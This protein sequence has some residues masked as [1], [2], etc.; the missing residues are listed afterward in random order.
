MPD[1]SAWGIGAL[2]HNG[3]SHE[4]VSSVYV[5]EQALLGHYVNG[6][7]GI[8]K[9]EDNMY[10]ESVDWGRCFPDEG[11]GER[12]MVFS[13]VM[14][15]G[16]KQVWELE[17]DER[18]IARTEEMLPSI[19]RIM[20]ERLLGPA[21]KEKGI[22]RESIS[23]N[24]VPVILHPYT[25]GALTAEAE[26]IKVLIEGD[27][28]LRGYAEAI[29]KL[30]SF[31]YHERSE[32]ILSL[33]GINAEILKQDRGMRELPNKDG[34]V[35]WARSMGFGYTYDGY[36]INLDL[37]KQSPWSISAVQFFLV[38]QD[39]DSEHCVLETDDGLFIS[40]AINVSPGPQEGVK[41]SQIVRAYAQDGFKGAEMELDG[42]N[43]MTVSVCDVAGNEFVVKAASFGVA[44]A[45]EKEVCWQVDGASRF[46]FRSLERHLVLQAREQSTPQGHLAALYSML[47]GIPGGMLSIPLPELGT[48]TRVL[49]EQILSGALVRHPFADLGNI[50]EAR[51]GVAKK[52]DPGVGPKGGGGPE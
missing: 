43:C 14:P 41:L 11:E 24:I 8:T 47:P 46:P 39:M 48:V 2:T 19:V 5:N 22:S 1:I 23:M 42:D 30:R 51:E 32:K 7:M 29:L 20:G 9:R 34:I 36:V 16:K 21:L 49:S 17:G 44:T 13:L 50:D 37:T 28:T 31:L 3:T 12:A 15:D 6:S 4:Y 45:F 52:E 25:H 35:S 10:D 18:M 26:K 33:Q 38:T 40:Q 27:E